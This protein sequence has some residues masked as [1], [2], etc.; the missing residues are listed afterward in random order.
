MDCDK[1]HLNLILK[2]CQVCLKEKCKNDDFTTKQNTCNN[3]RKKIIIP[4]ESPNACNWL[5]GNGTWCNEEIVFKNKCDKHCYKEPTGCHHQ[6]PKRQHVIKFC[7][8]KKVDDSDFCEKHNEP[9][10]VYCNDCDILLTIENKSDRN[11]C[12]ECKN[13]SYLVRIKKKLQELKENRITTLQCNTCE[14]YKEFEKFKDVLRNECRECN[15]G[16][17]FDTLKI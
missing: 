7:N 8:K 3:C 16:I 13:S 6:L 17:P 5:L 9:K 1:H 10:K 15:L 4:D 2:K 11:K 14:I 12:K